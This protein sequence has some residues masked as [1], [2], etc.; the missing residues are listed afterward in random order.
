[1]AASFATSMLSTLVRANSGIQSRPAAVKPEQLL[2]LYDIEN[3]P[4]CRLVRE[5]LTELDLDAQILPCPRDGERFRPEVVEQGGKAQFPYLVDPNT[6]EAM[7][8]SLDIVAYLFDTYGQRDLPLR[9]R[10][11]R[12]QTVGSMLASAPRLNKGMRARPGQVPDLPL[13]LYSFESSPYARP[14]RELL[15][16]MEMPYMLRNCGRTRLDEWLLPPLR[17]RLNVTPQSTIE[18]RRVLQEREGRVAIPYLY[19]PNSDRGMFE[20]ADILDYLQQIY[21]A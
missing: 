9:W 5:A 18:N 21:A 7:Y 13:E 16:A 4:Y 6:G 12:L 2:R 11:G 19:D 14:V 10:A 17:E 3:C 1:M 8:E 20:S 15:C